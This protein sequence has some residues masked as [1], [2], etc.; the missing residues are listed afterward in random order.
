MVNTGRCLRKPVCAVISPVCVCVVKKAENSLLALFFGRG[1]CG[2]GRTQLVEVAEEVR[3]PN[4]FVIV[5]A[6]GL[7]GCFGK[8]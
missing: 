8:R 7:V 1:P 5:P 4:G 2:L 6:F 3:R